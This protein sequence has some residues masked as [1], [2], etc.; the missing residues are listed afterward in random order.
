MEQESKKTDWPIRSTAF[1]A[2]MVGKYGGAVNELNKVQD[3]RRF[4]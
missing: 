4:I 2:Y 3:K 1:V